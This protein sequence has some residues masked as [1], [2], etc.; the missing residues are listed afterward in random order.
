MRGLRSLIGLV[1]A[2]AIETWLYLD[3]QAHEARVHWFTHF[4]IGAGV[5]LI[6]MT[7]WIVEERR[8]VAVPALWLVFGHVVAMLPDTMFHFGIPHRR[9]MDVFLAH[10]SAHTVP[11]G[12]LTWYALF[13]A[14]LAGYLAAEVRRQER[15]RA[16]G[17]GRRRHGQHPARG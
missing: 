9:W 12:N 2:V 13:L 3:Y 5:A 8:R 17:D 10:I 1:V 11:G 7:V 15:Q 4:F 6:G 16:L 14:A